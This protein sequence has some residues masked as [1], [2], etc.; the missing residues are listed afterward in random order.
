VKNPAL[1]VQDLTTLTCS[2]VGGRPDSHNITWTKDGTVVASV[3]G[4]TLNYSTRYSFPSP[5]GT[6]ICTV[7]SLYSREEKS[8]L[9]QEKGR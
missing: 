3:H 4:N 6:Y 2:A 1:E 9:I 8:V 5:F 7:E